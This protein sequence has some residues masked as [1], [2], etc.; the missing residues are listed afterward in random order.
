[1]V[2][3]VLI[4]NDVSSVPDTSDVANTLK[5][6]VNS[7]NSNFSLPVDIST[8]VATRKKTKTIITKVYY[9]LIYD[10]KVYNLYLY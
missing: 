8:I 6:A 3:V 2:D 4:F 1:M 5:A 7:S 9:I 10:H